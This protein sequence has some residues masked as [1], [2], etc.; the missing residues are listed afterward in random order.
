MDKNRGANLWPCAPGIIEPSQWWCGDKSVTPMCHSGN[1]GYIRDYTS[2]SIL[3]FPPTTSSPSTATQSS[4]DT[5]T[6]TFYI[7]ASF[8]A[9]LSKAP[10][11]SAQT[12]RRS[13]NVP[14]DPPAPAQSQ[15]HSAGLPTAIGFGVGIPLSIAAIGFLGFLYWRAVKRQ[16]KSESRILSQEHALGNGDQSASVVINRPSTKLPEAQL[17]IELDDTGRRELPGI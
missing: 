2:G 8:S 17:P 1:Q 11:L 7:P 10:S 9:K 13:T 15:E 6:T 16:D 4:C 12:Q 14:T 5:A 3:G